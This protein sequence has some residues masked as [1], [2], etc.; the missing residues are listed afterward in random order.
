[1]VIPSTTTVG[2]PMEPQMG[3]NRGPPARATRF[4][5]VLH[6]DLCKVSAVL[7]AFAKNLSSQILRDHLAS[8]NDTSCVLQVASQD[9]LRK[10]KDIA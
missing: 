8:G 4:F 5:A 1:M 6:K 9:E 3:M 2:A 10:A 7:Q